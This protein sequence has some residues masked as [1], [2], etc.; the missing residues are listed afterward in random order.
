MVTRREGLIGAFS[1]IMP[2]LPSNIIRSAAGLESV[3]NIVRV[4][5]RNDLAKLSRDNAAIAYLRES[6]RQGIF[7]WQSVNLTR[8]VSRDTEQALYVAPDEDL[9]GAS[10]AW[11]RQ[12]FG[13]P[14]IEWFGAASDGISD[15]F[16]AFQA[17]A[18]LGLRI[19]IRAG[20]YAL[21]DSI[22]LSDGTEF[23]GLGKAVLKSTARDKGLFYA[24]NIG[25]FQL[26]GL[27]LEG[28][29]ASP[30]NPVQV[31]DRSAVAI[32]N[33]EDC[34]IE[35]CQFTQWHG[36]GI[37]FSLEG[38]KA[39]GKVLNCRFT[40]GDMTATGTPYGVQD[41]APVQVYQYGSNIT[42]A[43]CVA[44]GKW[45]VGFL[46]QDLVNNG[47]SRIHGLKVHGNTFR[48]LSQYGVVCYTAGGPAIS[49]FSANAKG[50]FR[51]VTS[52][53]HHLRDGDRVHLSGCGDASGIW[54]V[55]I[56]TDAAFD[57]INSR[58]SKHT[59][60][61]E[62]RMSE[63]CAG[64]IF[65]NIIDGVAG[66]RTSGAGE[67]FGAGIYFQSVGGISAYGNRIAR[68]NLKTTTQTLAPGGLGIN[69]ATGPISFTGGEIRNV[70]FHGISIV[71]IDCFGPV[72]IGGKLSIDNP[73]RNAIDLFAPRF[74]TLEEI[75]IVSNRQGAS[76]R[77]LASPQATRGQNLVLR[78]I[79][80]SDFDVVASN[81][82]LEISNID[83]LEVSGMMLRNAKSLQYQLEV[84]RFT[85]CTQAL[86][87][88]NGFD[89]G[90]SR[91]AAL[92][93]TNTT[94][95]VF[96]QNVIRSQAADSSEPVVRMR[97][98]CTGTVYHADND[99]RRAGKSGGPAENT[100]VGG[101][102]HTK[103]MNNNSGGKMRQSGDTILNTG[104]PRSGPCKWIKTKA[105]A[106]GTDWRS[107]SRC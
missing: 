68:T 25:W 8:D 20:T 93:I 75:D 17:A 36:S 73:A 97:G 104:F 94:N 81:N 58:Y 72:Y 24:A 83:Q 85:N 45:Y 37:T 16:P 55:A 107:V 78:A 89:G 48:D 59:F 13:D 106:G 21:S 61:G 57:L 9:S 28:N 34:R 71:S 65:D 4:A 11:V 103:A 31:R 1:L 49:R 7:E 41:C 35:N 79:T 82:I 60:L 56:V 22:Q 80:C 5:T 23:Y 43:N 99:A 26:N 30:G 100:S 69:R 12:Y 18:D 102:M 90:M 74:V 14:S 50:A 70:G 86:V 47:I 15:D 46:A 88:G 96:A 76:S 67:P 33:V 92:V 10:G 62:M 51:V 39:S 95:S 64:E 3:P 32:V 54:E 42:M 38:K 6:G 19:S 44:S 29:I 66:D 77:I 40:K 2:L 98:R 105:S 52:K 101:Q 84:A 63:N 87:R 27:E 91:D 53:A